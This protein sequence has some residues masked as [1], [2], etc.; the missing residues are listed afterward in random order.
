MEFEECRKLT[1]RVLGRSPG[2]KRILLKQNS[3]GIACV[4]DYTCIDFYDSI[5]ILSID[6]AQLRFAKLHGEDTHRNFNTPTLIPSFMILALGPR[7]E[8][9]G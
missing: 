4:Y 5:I 1:Q 2:N 3:Q 7:P 8:D 6:T 9:L